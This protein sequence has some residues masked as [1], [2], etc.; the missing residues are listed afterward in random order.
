MYCWIIRMQ[1]IESRRK[2]SIGW[3]RLGIQR[4]I[5][6]KE[7]MEKDN[8]SAREAFNQ[9]LDENKLVQMFLTTE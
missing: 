2:C 7:R 8:L 1:D 4:Q 3:I 9:N 6:V 5:N